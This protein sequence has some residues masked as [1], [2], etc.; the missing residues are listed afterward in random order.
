M[1]DMEDIYASRKSGLK[2][3]HKIL[4]ACRLVEDEIL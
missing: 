4:S 1:D 3:S 2:E